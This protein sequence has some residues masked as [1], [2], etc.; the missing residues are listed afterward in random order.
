MRSKWVRVFRLMAAA[1]ALA[2]G[3]G[4]FGLGCGE[5]WTPAPSVPPSNEMAAV[6]WGGG[7][8]VAVGNG[9]RLASPDG[10]TWES[11]SNPLGGPPMNAVAY[12][13]H[14]FVVPGLNSRVYLSRD[15]RRWSNVYVGERAWLIGAAYGDG[16]FVVVG[17]RGKTFMSVDGKTW[18]PS[19]TA[20]RKLLT[21]VAFGRHRF[22][23]VGEGGSIF[24]SRDGLTWR[25]VAHGA[26]AFSGVTYGAAGFVAVGQFGEIWTSPDG[27]SWSLGPYMPG[28]PQLNAV[29]YTGTQYVIVGDG[30]LILT[31]L[32]GLS[33][34]SQDSGTQ[35]GLY[36]VAGNSST[37]VAV[38]AAEGAQPGCTVL[39]STC[40]P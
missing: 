5:A 20:S 35:A 23:T 39:V 15:G 37:I 12:G 26:S 36:G 14:T 33:W 32:G 11:Y 38:G 4:I 31:S 34:T 28:E 22:V 17:E 6:T 13:N 27:R 30:G 18:Y 8:F 9:M 1:C 25:R 19:R 24:S 21:A 40:P 3:V 16:I 29:A 2:A 10:L 7:E